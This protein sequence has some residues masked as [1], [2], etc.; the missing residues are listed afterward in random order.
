MGQKYKT[1]YIRQNGCRMR[2]V[3]GLLLCAFSLEDYCVA[4]SPAIPTEVTQWQRWLPPP[5]SVAGPHE[6]QAKLLSQLRD[7]VVKSDSSSKGANES[8]LSDADVQL[9]KEAMKQYGGNLPNGLSPDILDS[10]PTDVI[11]KALADPELMR[12]AREMADQLPKS[13]DKSQPQTQSKSDAYKDLLNK[14]LKAQEQFEKNQKEPKDSLQ[15]NGSEN[16]D[17]L[18]DNEILQPQSSGTN[19]P[20]KAIQKP[21][22]PQ[23][24]DGSGTAPS[25]TTPSATPQS[26]STPRSRTP[27]PANSLLQENRSRQPTPT[28]ERNRLSPNTPNIE[29]NPNISQ[30]KTS[31]QPANG[32]GAP[33]SDVN[34]K[35]SSRGNTG[36]A[37]ALEANDIRKELDR[38]GISSALQKIFEKS[39]ANIA[40]RSKSNA[41]QSVESSAN[42]AKS[43]IESKNPVNASNPAKQSANST[44]SPNSAKATDPNFKPATPRV[45]QPE[46]DFSKSMKQANNYINNMWT[47]VAKS[48]RGTTTAQSPPANA[49]Q[50][51]AA[52]E[53]IRLSAPFDG[54]VLTYL[55]VLAIFCAVAYFALRYRVRSEQV[56]KET[57]LAQLVQSVDEIRTRDDFVHAFHMLARQRF[58]AAQSWWTCGFVATQFE[59]KL[60]QYKSPIQTLSKL[61][62]QARYYPVEHQLT[63]K[64]FDEAKLAIKQCKG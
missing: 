34:N 45:P 52:N 2:I 42:A 33:T 54:R 23:P 28:P 64:Q 13:T 51:P 16:D 48:T 58:Q 38:K 27:P 49:P 22:S 11:S 6:A 8:S 61:Y 31:Q 26:G 63:A 12:Q 10:I 21:G 36:D 50:A 32:P 55:A 43:P 3:F 40:Q 41:A 9:L 15:T 57:Q 24:N 20:N 59:T 39:R 29:S 47:Q 53:A 14:L 5:R 35:S 30:R 62:D 37:S 46:S 19:Q 25:R 18:F 4:Q 7:M 17:L 44:A 60:P 1:Q 56:R